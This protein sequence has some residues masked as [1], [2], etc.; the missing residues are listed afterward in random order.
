MV[1]FGSLRCPVAAGRYV[2]IDEFLR[3]YK[4]VVSLGCQL[5]WSSFVIECLFVSGVYSLVRFIYIHFNVLFLILIV[6]IFN[7]Y[8]F[9][10]N[11]ARIPGP[12]CQVL[13]Y[14]KC[15][16][17]NPLSFINALAQK[18]STQFFKTPFLCTNTALLNIT[19]TNSFI[20]KVTRK[21]KTISNT[22]Q[23]I[24]D[25]SHVKFLSDHINPSPNIWESST[26]HIYNFY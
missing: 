7:I 21:K 4:K 13:V 15:C 3:G 22:L 12:R 1:F 17:C 23:K 18:D 16:L 25:W 24:H 19:T 9:C 2:I 26:M 20:Y 10:P 11:P 8:F 5:N 6:Y 14:R